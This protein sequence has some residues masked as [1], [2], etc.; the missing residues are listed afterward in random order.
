MKIQIDQA[1][2]VVDS[3]TLA[4]LADWVIEQAI[5][6]QQIAAPTFSER[7]RAELVAAQFAEHNLV[8]IDIDEVHNVYGRLQGTNPALAALMVVAHTDTVFGAE[9][10]LTLRRDPQALYGPGIGDNSLGVGGMLGVLRMFF[11]QKVKPERDIWFVATSCEEGL[12]DLR[13]MRAAFS[14]LKTRLAGVVNIEGLA[15][16]HVYH[17]GIAVKRL[18]I[19][20]HTP[21]GHSW[22]HFGRPSAIHVLMALGAKIAAIR[23]PTNPRTTHNIG[24]IDGGTSINSIA[25]SASIWLDMRSE[26]MGALARL[27]DDVRNLIH[28]VTTPET[29]FTVDVVGER[30]AGYLSPDHPLVRA[31]VEALSF[32]GVKAT[33]ETGSTDG[34]IALAAGCPTVTVGVTRGGN[35]HRLD[36][37]AELAAVRDGMQQLITLVLAASTA[38]SVL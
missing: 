9:T 17:A 33:L 23:P 18:H 27:E 32:V 11:A 38:G 20:C 25:A 1:S 35:A 6:I 37:Y 4:A 10:D 21:G 34:N 31:A 19:I 29:T 26:D 36:E 12:G 22:L 5:G 8:D 24:L 13:G 14:R 15:F 3:S 2:R 28:T 16:G 7:P 30:P